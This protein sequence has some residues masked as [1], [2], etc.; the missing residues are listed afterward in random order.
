MIGS[1]RLVLFSLVGMVSYT[2]AYYFDYALVRFY[3]VTGEI[4]WLGSPRGD[5]AS[6]SWY[7]WIATGVLAGVIVASLTPKRVAQRISADAVWLL[8]AITVAAALLYEKR[9]FF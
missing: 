4:Q 6:I 7:G 2:F 3:P 8:P 5:T 1:A 9:W